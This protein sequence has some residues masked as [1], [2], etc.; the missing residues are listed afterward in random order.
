MCFFFSLCAHLGISFPLSPSSFQLSTQPD[1]DNKMMIK[2]E[3]EEEE[4][5]PDL[6]EQDFNP[7]SCMNVSDDGDDLNGNFEEGKAEERGLIP[8]DV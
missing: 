5:Q 8:F 3:E 6:E 4:E 7:Q 2:E 1:R